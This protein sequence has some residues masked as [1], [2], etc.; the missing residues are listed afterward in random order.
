MNFETLI[1]L[2]WEVAKNNPDGFTLNLN[3]ETPTSGFVVAYQDTQNSFEKVGLEKSIKHAIRND[4]FFGGWLNEDG[5]LQF[6]S[7]KVITNKDEAIEFGRSQN[8][9]AIWHIDEM[10]EIR[11]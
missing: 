5:I 9:R 10:T 1:D 3:F 11:L 2:A 4:G 7:V 6:D 8:Q